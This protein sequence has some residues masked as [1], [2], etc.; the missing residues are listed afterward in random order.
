[1]EDISITL[2]SGLEVFKEKASV[3]LAP[4]AVVT[5]V[6]YSS[7]SALFLAPPP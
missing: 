7:R 6:T 5:N 1:M 3:K 4:Q 2:C